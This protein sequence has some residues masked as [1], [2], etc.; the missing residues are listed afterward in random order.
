MSEPLTHAIPFGEYGTDPDEMMSLIVAAR[1]MQQGQL[2]MPAVIGN[3]FPPAFRAR[4]AKQTLIELGYGMVEVGMGEAGF[5]ASNQE[6][7]S[8][9][10]YLAPGVRIQNGRQL[11]RWTLEQTEEPIT[12]VLNSGFTDAAWLWMDRPD[13]MLEKVAS[14]IIMGGIVIRDGLPVLDEYG[15]LTPSLGKGG[16]A[17]N[18]FDPG[19]TR[20]L[21]YALQEHNVP[22]VITT[23]EAGYAAKLPFELFARMAATG[24]TIGVRLNHK[25]V[26]SINAL[27]QKANAAAGSEIRGKLPVDRNRSWFVDTFCGREDPG[28]SPDDDISPFVREVTLYDPINLI[29]AIPALR[30]RFFRPHL[31]QVAQATHA[32]IGLTRENHG[33]MNPDDLRFFLL[34]ALLEA[35][36]TGR[37]AA[38]TA[39]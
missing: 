23:R 1:L 26:R 14:V 4:Q 35:L 25:Q 18:V 31:V 34:D 10:T 37:D 32:I 9:A 36:K 5:G 39:N 22:M 12:L 21:F 17:N 2:Y 20:H 13:L 29:A 19:A 30:D 27:W 6:L 38:L 15:H 28:I 8:D 11:L 24:H 3:H 16:A 7:E 33:V